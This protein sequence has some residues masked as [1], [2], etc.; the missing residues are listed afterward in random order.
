MGAGPFS[1]PSSS[2]DKRYPLP[3]VITTACIDLRKPASGTGSVQLCV[4][5][6]ER[7]KHYSCSRGTTRK[8]T[9]KPEEASPG[10]A[11]TARC[12][13]ST[14]ARPFLNVAVIT[15][16]VPHLLRRT[17]VFSIGG[18]LHNEVQTRD[19][20]PARNDERYSQGKIDPRQPGE[21][22]HVLVYVQ[23][24]FD[25]SAPL[26]SIGC[27]K[28]RLTPSRCL[29]HIRAAK[30]PSTLRHEC[31]DSFSRHFLRVVS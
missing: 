8:S 29:A 11:R 1:S 6:K 17:H 3:D 16:I 25:V 28:D 15:R 2:R 24:L 13:F 20:K 30:R 7:E 27:L 31:L 12:C 5:G 9:R 10:P 23:E 19:P 21:P 26:L 4:P 22:T 14:A 18:K